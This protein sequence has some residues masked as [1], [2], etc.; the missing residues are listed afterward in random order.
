MVAGHLMRACCSMI[1][2]YMVYGNNIHQE[3]EVRTFTFLVWYLTHSWLT[4]LPSLLS[5]SEIQLLCGSRCLIILCQYCSVSFW[6]T[7]NI[8]HDIFRWVEL[9]YFTLCPGVFNSH[10]TRKVDQKINN[11][12]TRLWPIYPPVDQGLRRGKSLDTL[13]T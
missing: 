13:I 11:R 2:I 5:L 9:K 4:C 7:L 10:K 3:K 12:T 6:S 1:L 8:L